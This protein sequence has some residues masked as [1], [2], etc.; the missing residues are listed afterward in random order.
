[1]WLS[2]FPDGFCLGPAVRCFHDADDD[3][4]MMLIIDGEISLHTTYFRNYSFLGKS[5]QLAYNDTWANYFLHMIHIQQSIR[6]IFHWENGGFTVM[7]LCSLSLKK[8]FYKR[9]DLLQTRT[10][11]K[12]NIL[13]IRINLIVNCRLCLAD[14]GG[15]L[16]C[17]ASFTLTLDVLTLCTVL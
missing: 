1:M 2:S 13:K 11:C 6:E 17:L 9:D 15:F 3:D 5:A 16:L 7:V 8:L 12:L 10:F 14:V 4:F